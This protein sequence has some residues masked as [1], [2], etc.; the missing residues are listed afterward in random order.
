M[1]VIPSVLHPDIGVMDMGRKSELLEN[2]N[3]VPVEVDFIPL[4]PVARRYWIGVMVVVPPIS[5]T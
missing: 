2:P 4:Q 5:E 1:T 3:R